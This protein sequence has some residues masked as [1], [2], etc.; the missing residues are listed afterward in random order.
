MTLVKSRAGNLY[1]EEKGGGI[2]I[3]LIHP[4]GA[5]AST[6][7]KFAEDLAEFGRVIA[8]DRRGYR[9]SG[10]EPVRS[11]R[12]HTA[13]AAALLE[14]LE[15][16]PAVVVGTSIGATIA[17]DVAL[18]RP[19]LVGAV[20]A[21]ESPWRV[22]HQPPTTSQLTALARMGWLVSR[23]R[24]ADAAAVFLRFAHTYRDGASAWDSFPDEWQQTVSENSKA[25]VTDIRIAISGYPAPKEL[26]DIKRP[27]VCSHGARSPNTMVKVTRALA[28]AVPTS[29]VT[30]IEGAGHA[31]AFDAP[32]NFVR[33]IVDA[34]QT[35]S[36]S[37]QVVLRPIKRE[38]SG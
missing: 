19:D 9:R 31:P 25:A 29:V 4:S 27:V 12:A 30:E 15:T 28:R 33:V 23:G 6:W 2:P 13:D 22:T 36:D 32:D 1:Y 8:Y 3:L 18:R 38:H 5:T 16:L 7:G 21:H 14:A 35:T 10:G 11:I 37:G 24:H 17:I 34:T 26:A 20:V